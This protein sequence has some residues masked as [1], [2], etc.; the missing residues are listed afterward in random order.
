MGVSV[1]QGVFDDRGRDVSRLSA[2]S[3]LIEGRDLVESQEV[4][5]C[6]GL[7]RWLI[8]KVE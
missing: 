8:R 6:V 4:V 7:L 3:C 1:G 2:S 5:L